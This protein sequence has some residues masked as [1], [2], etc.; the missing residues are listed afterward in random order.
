MRISEATREREHIQNY[1]QRSEESRGIICFETRS[2]EAE[3]G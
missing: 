2:L 1:V 3:G